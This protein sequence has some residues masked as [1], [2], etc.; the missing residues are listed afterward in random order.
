MPR[1][2]RNNRNNLP[3]QFGEFCIIQILINIIGKRI[4]IPLIP[5]SHDRSRDAEIELDRFELAPGEAKAS[6]AMGPRLLAH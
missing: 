2:R 6:T 3:F 5:L 4:R 1:M